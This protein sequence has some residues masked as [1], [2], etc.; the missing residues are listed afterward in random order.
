VTISG[1]L[2]MLNGGQPLA[3]APIELQRVN[4]AGETTLATAVTDAA[5]G[6]SLTVTVGRDTVVRALHRPAPAAVSELVT[7]GVVPVLTLALTASS[8]PRVSGTITP[9][10]AF[11]V[12]DTYELLARG[13]GRLLASRRVRV[14]GGRFGGRVPGVHPGRRLAVAAR[15]AEGGGTLA[16]HSPTVTV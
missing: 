16:G 3:A 10:K 6:W 4:G 9:A 14:R 12:I 15:T 1:R 8:P 11:V 7:I 13:R 5:G 2:A